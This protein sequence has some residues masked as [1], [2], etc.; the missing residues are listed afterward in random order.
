ML[1]RTKL[2]KV[3]TVLGENTADKSINSTVLLNR[4]ALKIWRVD[5][6]LRDVTGTVMN[7]QVLIEGTLHKQIFYVGLDDDRIFH[8]PEDIPFSTF[9][10]FPQVTHV[11]GRTLKAIVTS[12]VQKVNFTLSDTNP[13]E[14][15]QQVIVQ[16]VVKVVETMQMNVSLSNTGPLIK[17]DV[18]IGE[19]TAAVVA[20]AEVLLT[21]PAVKVREV[22][23]TVGE[24]T[25]EVMPDHVS[26]TGN[27]KSQVFFVSSDQVARH[28]AVEFPFSAIVE[29]AGAEPGM[30]VDVTAQVVRVD[31]SLTR[32]GTAVQLRAILQIFAKVTETAQVSVEVLPTGPL[33]RTFRVIGEKTAQVLVEDTA[34]LPLRAIKVQDVDCSVKDVTFE[35]LTHKVVVNGIV[36][37]QVFF[38]STDDVLRHFPEDI[39]FSC[40]IDVPGAQPGMDVH[41][42]ARCEH[43]SWR[44]TN[45]NPTTTSEITDSI[46]SS[47]FDEVLV[48]QT[49]SETPQACGFQFLRQ[50]VVVD[51]FVKLSEESQLNIF[52][53]PV[54]T[55][56]QLAAIAA[57]NNPVVDG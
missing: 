46:L 31:K 50:R 53:A 39:P 13:R 56:S 28:Q 6:S 12:K 17:A 38:V 29:V 48:G 41:T 32:N 37:K 25:A 27:V 22:R 23:T 45:D 36:H 54:T 43:I 40:V 55:A 42:M 26:I 35:V 2:L 19:N 1:A 18:V 47:G 49:V 52:A 15:E 8:Q 34:R 11:Q 10:P 33:V 20:T 9:V 7:G 44:L 51:V 3:D 30:N 5:A 21:R 57:A 14:L 4:P 16:F 24:V